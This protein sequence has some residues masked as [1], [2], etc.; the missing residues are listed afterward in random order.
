MESRGFIVG[1]P[2]AYALGCGM[3]VIRKPGKLPAATFSAD[4]ELEYGTDSIEMHQDTFSAESRVLLVDDLLATGGTAQAAL[5]LIQQ[6]QG[7]VIEVAFLIELSALEGRQRLAPC[8][9]FA[10]MEYE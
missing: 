2:L 7:N 3:G 1:A 9:V 10:L 4:Y 5:K 6:L 8:E